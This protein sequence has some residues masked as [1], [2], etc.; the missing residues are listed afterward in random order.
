[1]NL[2]NIIGI[3]KSIEDEFETFIEFTVRI[4]ESG[5]GFVDVICRT[6]DKRF[7]ELLEV[8]QEVAVEGRLASPWFHMYVECTDIIIIK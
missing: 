7:K 8:N 6:K 4:E 1:M 5:V 3:V 2:V